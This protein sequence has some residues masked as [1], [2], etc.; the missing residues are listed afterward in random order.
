[1][2]D[3]SG[4][5]RLE[6]KSLTK[7][8]R[9]PFTHTLRELECHVFLFFFGRKGSCICSN[10]H[11]DRETHGCPGFLLDLLSF[12][13]ILIG[14]RGSLCGQYTPYERTESSKI[15]RVLYML[16]FTCVFSVFSGP[17]SIFL[18]LEG[19]IRKIPPKLHF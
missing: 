4:M 16:F 18:T 17:C 9:C 6:N 3:R 13:A 11:A 5:V 15:S 1:M 14:Q 2:N 12:V 19:V 10:A 7:S 8:D